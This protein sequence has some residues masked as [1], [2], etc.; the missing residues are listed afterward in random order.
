MANIKINPI[1]ENFDFKKPNYV[2]I[3]RYRN[4]LLKSLRSDENLLKAYKTHY[5]IWSPQSCYDWITDWLFTF[6]P[7]KKKNAYM[8]FILFPK[9]VELLEWYFACIDNET[10]GVLEKSR[11][12]G[13]SY[14]SL[15]FALWVLLNIPEQM[16]G[17][18]SYKS[19]FVDTI[20]SPNSLLEKVRIM[21]RMIPKEFM[22][23]FY[24]NGKKYHYDV[25]KDTK[26]K[27]IP[28]PAN[29]SRIVGE[30]GDN[31]GRAGRS[32]VYFVDES[33]HL[34]RPK[35][36]DAAL[37]ANSPC[38]IHQS[39]VN[40]PVPNGF[41]EKRFSN[42]WPV[43]I[44]KWED[45][46]R[47]DI[48]W[49][50][51][52]QRLYEHAPWIMAQEYDRDYDAAVEGTFI[53]AIWV[54]AAINAHVHKEKGWAI[55]GKERSGL[56][57]AD[58]G[59]ADN[60]LVIAKGNVVLSVETWKK[61]F[62][63]DTVN[64]AY[65]E[66]SLA[67]VEL[68]RYDN[69]GVGAGAKKTFRDLSENKTNTMRFEGINVGSRRLIGRFNKD[70]TNKEM[71]YNLKARLWWH[72]RELFYNTYLYMHAD[73]PGITPSM[74]ISIPDDSEL[75]AQISGPKR[76]EDEETQLILVESKKSLRKRGVVKMDCADAFMLAISPPKL[77]P[78]AKA[79]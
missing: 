33:A 79:H 32:S 29:N 63:D 4:E 66:S 20:G 3:Y 59:Q 35:K 1:T 44:V 6:D 78:S 31:I 46:P 72:A 28:N 16:I 2:T 67:K 36:V 26:H 60:C 9:Q 19:D 41:A 13:A 75:V 64:K 48:K 18:G 21:M 69:V 37:S 70:K 7:R 54:R 42:Q 61:P 76:V 71:F 53:P 52:K 12:V 27:L 50:R 58:S 5:G 51:K 14:V 22:P 10:G 68:L 65:T 23:V 15:A 43:Y 77:F 34:V 38:V 49:Y 55:T 24:R 57:I 56:D 45:D 62:I 11:D 8:P 40:G 47:K 25:D 39:S 17:F 74:C 30:V 73:H